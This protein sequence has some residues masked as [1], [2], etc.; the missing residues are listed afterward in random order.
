MWMTRSMALVATVVA[1]ACAGP[2]L[3]PGGPGPGEVDVGYG[4]QDEDDVTGAVTSVSE[5]E[6]DA[7][8]PLPIGELLRG[9]V[10][11]LQV[12]Q[13]P[14]GSASYRLRGTNSMLNDQE[15][16]FVI[17]SVPISP[18]NVPAALA[19]LIPEDIRQVDVLKDVSSTSIFG[20]RAAGGVIVITTRH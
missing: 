11:G 14:D 19:S 15:P 17:D 13:R 4:T 1:A 3:P 16:L 10:P 9:R 18:A 7:A 2:G 12:I 8:Q 20:S 5:A 6:I